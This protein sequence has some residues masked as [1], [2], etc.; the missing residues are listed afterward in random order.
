MQKILYR[1]SYIQTYIHTDAILL[2]RQ[3]SSISPHTINAEQFVQ[4]LLYT[5]ALSCI[6]TYIH[7]YI[8]TDAIL[9]SRQTSSVLPHTLNAENF[10]QILLTAQGIIFK[11]EIQ[12]S[13]CVFVRVYMCVNVCA[14]VNVYVFVYVYV[15]VYVYRF[16]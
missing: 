12:R 3:T 7:T 6:H 1:F 4:I 8:H 9:L 11:I 5:Y 10:V 2:S 14:F 16:S 13:V 15:Y